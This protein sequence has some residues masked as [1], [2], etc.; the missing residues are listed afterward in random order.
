M[1]LKPLSVIE[2]DTIERRTEDATRRRSKS[3][4]VHAAH[5]VLA[6][7]MGTPPKILADDLAVDEF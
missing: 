5:A 7:A 1:P 4:N 2:L 6:A 3:I